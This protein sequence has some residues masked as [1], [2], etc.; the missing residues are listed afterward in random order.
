MIT[1][2]NMNKIL[3]GRILAYFLF[4]ILTN[5]SGFQANKIKLENFPDI[6]KDELKYLDL[7]YS[8]PSFKS[9]LVDSRFK[10]LGL[11]QADGTQKK[12]CEIIA[13]IDSTNRF[14]TCPLI[15]NYIA[16]FTL[17][18][19]PY[20]CARHYEAHAT[21]LTKNKNPNSQEK[22]KILKEYQ[23]SDRVDEVWS[24]LLFLAAVPITPL[25]KIDTPDQAK[26]KTYTRISE[27]IVRQVLNDAKNFKECQ[28]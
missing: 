4:F 13:Y 5:C 8:K 3:K 25:R 9:I 27:A 11:R 18:T 28:K 12:G 24:S 20:Y 22:Y 2:K 10:D 17:F 19:I 21:L 16:P 14:L 23:L 15:T 1:D 7:Y 26:S 6:R